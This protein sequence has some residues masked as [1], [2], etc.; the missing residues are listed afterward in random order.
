MSITRAK[1]PPGSGGGFQTAHTESAL[2]ATVTLGTG[3]SARLPIGTLYEVGGPILDTTDPEE[4]TVIEA[5]IYAVTAAGGVLGS[6]ETGLGAFILVLDRVNQG[7]AT[8][9]SVEFDP[10]DTFTSVSLTAYIPAGGQI[11]LTGENLTG[12]GNVD[13]FWRQG[14]IQRIT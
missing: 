1:N 3:L 5:G 7:W 12:T 8:Q 9:A 6:A 10:G 11:D 13:F 14:E 4:P 2:G